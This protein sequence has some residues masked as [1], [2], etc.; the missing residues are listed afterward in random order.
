[1]EKKQPS[2]SQWQEIEKNLDSFF[3]VAYLRCDGYLI[4]A[5]M[6]RVG[7]NKLAI[8]VAVNGYLLKGEWFPSSSVTDTND[9][10]EVARRFLRPTSRARMN[11]KEL[12]LWEKI[13]G[14][15]ECKK[16]GYYDRIIF[17]KTEWLRPRPFIAHL[18]KHN[19]SIEIIDY[20]TYSRE[21]EVLHS[22]EAEDA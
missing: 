8:V 4:S 9:L 22:K 13:I 14:K 5:T 2:K 1:M 7:K 10:H 20:E 11:Q 12:K 16:R 6:G 3:G 15:R 18:K 19:Q 17:P 21:V